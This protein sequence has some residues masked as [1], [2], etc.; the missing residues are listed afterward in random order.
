MDN[1][2]MLEELP[3]QEALR[4]LASVT[5]GRVVFTQRTLPAIPPVPHILDEGDVI[6]RTSLTTPIVGTTEQ[7]DPVVAYEADEIDADTRTGWSVVVTGVAQPV[8]DPL[9]R[10]RYEALLDCGADDP[11]DCVLR[12]RPEIAT[13][14]RVT[15]YP[16]N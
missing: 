1:R 15:P 13:G 8:R 7:S 16:E 12:I 2:R 6:I 11:A 3:R 5:M 10:A 4:L 9:D 14:L